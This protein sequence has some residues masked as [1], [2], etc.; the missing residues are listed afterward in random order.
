MSN[1]LLLKNAHGCPVPLKLILLPGRD[2]QHAQ[3]QER[4]RDLAATG[5]A[6]AQP[7]I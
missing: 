2:V 1:M 5:L 6:L 3:G 4:L 7:V